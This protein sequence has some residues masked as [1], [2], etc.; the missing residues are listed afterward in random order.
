MVQYL[1]KTM[2]CDAKVGFLFDINAKEEKLGQNCPNLKRNDF[3]DRKQNQTIS[4][5]PTSFQKGNLTIS[6]INKVVELGIVIGK[7]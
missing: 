7:T 3:I 1:S 6:N 4:F 5:K 2:N